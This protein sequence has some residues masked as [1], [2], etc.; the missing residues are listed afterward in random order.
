MEG[1]SYPG[2]A[3]LIC[4]VSVTDLTKNQGIGKVKAVQLRCKCI[5]E[6]SKRI[7]KVAAQSCISSFDH[8]SSIA[9]YSYGRTRHQE[10][11]LV[12]LYDAGQCEK[13]IFCERYRTSG[14]C[15]RHPGHTQWKYTWKPS[16][17]AVSLDLVHNHPGGDP[18]PS[19]CDR[20]IT[21]RICEAEELG[22]ESVF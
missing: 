15:N 21:Q 2:P 7:S 13:P 16:R 22:W 9:S 4:T 17:H 12:I 20:E 8:P 10:Q 11:E 6:L 14:N 1:T 18:E 19:G 3:G 5:G